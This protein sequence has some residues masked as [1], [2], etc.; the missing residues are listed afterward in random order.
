MS[1]PDP[2]NRRRKAR[3]ATIVYA[4]HPQTAIHSTADAPTSAA[5]ATLDDDR[6]HAVNSHK[7]L[8]QVHEGRPGPD[9]TTG[10]PGKPRRQAPQNPHRWNLLWSRLP[11]G[12]V[13]SLG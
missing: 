12:T 3:A 11:H 1:P 4:E 6:V 7:R 9:A 10:N 8:G 2:V 13:A 5:G